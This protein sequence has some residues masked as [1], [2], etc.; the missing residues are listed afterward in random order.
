MV[1]FALQYGDF[2]KWRNEVW[3]SALNHLEF[4]REDYLKRAPRYTRNIVERLCTSK[5][6]G[7]NIICDKIYFMESMSNWYNIQ[8]LSIHKIRKNIEAV[9]KCYGSK[10]WRLHKDGYNWHRCEE[11]YLLYLDLCP[12]AYDKSQ[13]QFSKSL[14]NSTI[15]SALMGVYMYM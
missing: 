14:G 4:K 12:C 13:Y 8:Y 15:A 6:I 11:F 10:I 2:Q 9:L 7:I 1:T 3:K 5:D